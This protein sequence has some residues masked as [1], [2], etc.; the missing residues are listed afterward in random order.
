M[1]RRGPQAR[2]RAPVSNAVSNGV[3]PRTI[4]RQYAR[5]KASNRPQILIGVDQ[6]SLWCRR[7][8]DLWQ[9]H[10]AD[11]GGEAN[12]SASELA[13][14]RRAITLTIQ[15]EQR[16]LRFALMPEDEQPT[17]ATLQVYQMMANSLRRLLESLHSGLERRSKDVTPTL[18]EYLRENYGSEAVG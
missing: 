16:E 9:L 1:A 6:R 3:V 18:D 13:I 2:S 10:T 5:S 8:K 7:Y 12:C 15:C 14:L 17:D 11:M 4:A